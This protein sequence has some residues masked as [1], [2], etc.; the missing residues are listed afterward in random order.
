M[1]KQIRKLCILMSILLY[2]KRTPKINFLKN[3]TCLHFAKFSDFSTNVFSIN[4]NSGHIRLSYRSISHWFISN[5]FKLILHFDI[6]FQF[7]SL[8]FLD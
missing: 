4:H 7:S 1:K 6:P 8:G 5:R 2:I 3:L